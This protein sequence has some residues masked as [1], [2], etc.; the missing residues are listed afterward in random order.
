MIPKTLTIGTKTKEQLLADLE[1]GGHKISE[2]AK[3]L[4]EKIEFSTTPQELQ[5]VDITISD[6]GMSEYPMT[7]QIK[8]RI[9][10]LGYSLVPQETALYL[11]LAYGDQPLGEWLTCFSKPIAG[12]AGRLGVLDVGR[13]SG[14]SWVSRRYAY[15][16]SVWDGGLRLLVCRTAS[17]PLEPSVL[18]DP[19]GL[20]TELVIN[21]QAYVKKEGHNE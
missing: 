17:S 11:R 20:P 4:V 13:G 15:P 16:D 7:V 1:K 10:A 21:G 19:C 12:A 9:E 5:L 6:L 14:G 3:E 8:K 2:W 18:S